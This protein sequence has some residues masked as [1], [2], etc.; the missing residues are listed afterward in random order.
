MSHSGLSVLGSV[1]RTGSRSEPAGRIVEPNS[2]LVSLS[3]GIES[4]ELIDRSLAEMAQLPYVEEILALPD[5][6]QKEMMEIPSSI[7]V[8]TRDVIVP[9][10]TSAAVNDGMGVVVT[11]IDAEIRQ[12]RIAHP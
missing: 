11:D 4:N 9:E 1:S 7:A 8:T 3:L 5:V 10:F 6:H 12:A 2:K